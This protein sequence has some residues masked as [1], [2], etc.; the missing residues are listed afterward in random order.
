ML[1]QLSVIVQEIIFSPNF[2][3][4]TNER[5]EKNDL[6]ANLSVGMQPVLHPA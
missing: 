2:V 1:Q 6:I 3:L 4:S 5:E